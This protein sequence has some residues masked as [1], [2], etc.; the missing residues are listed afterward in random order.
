MLLVVCLQRITNLFTFSGEKTKKKKTKNRF[1][2]GIDGVLIIILLLL[3]VPIFFSS[4]PSVYL[5]AAG[6]E[7]KKKAKQSSWEK[8]RVKGKYFRESKKG[9]KNIRKVRRG[10]RSDSVRK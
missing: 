10:R 4:P 3:P 8:G 6:G 2:T 1:L 9:V 7:K 5:F